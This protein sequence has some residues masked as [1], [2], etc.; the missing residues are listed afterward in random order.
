MGG[1][2]FVV[3]GTTIVAVLAVGAAVGA[4]AFAGDS[5]VQAAPSVT[6]SPTPSP[7]VSATSDFCGL[8]GEILALS[9]ESLAEQTALDASVDPDAAP[10]LEAIHASGQRTLDYVAEY[11][12]ILNRAAELAPDPD[13]AEALR[14]YASFTAD[15]GEEFGQI[16]VDAASVDEY[17]SALFATATDPIGQEAATAAEAAAPVV[18]DA[19]QSECGLDLAVA[20]GTAAVESGADSAR[21]D[22]ATLGVQIALYFVGWL[23]GEPLPVVTIRDGSYF[24]NDVNAGTVSDGVEIAD[25]AIVGWDDWCVAVTYTGDAPSTY[26]Y[27]SSE[28]GVEE[29]TCAALAGT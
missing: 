26:R 6:T 14:T 12:A 27:S 11:A 3:L 2:T 15:Q 13:V 16:A 17:F 21:L 22:A 20:M 28:T 5:A 24:V 19:A 1:G 29:G 18:V 10:T 25:Q 8:M 9:E 23:D 7:T 4:D